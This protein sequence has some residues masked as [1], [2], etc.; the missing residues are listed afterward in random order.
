MGNNTDFFNYV[1]QQLNLKR[2]ISDSYDKTYIDTLINLYYTKL[3]VDNAL[4]TKLNLT[5]ITN[6]YTKLQT[7]IF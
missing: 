2:N 3:Q 4:N 6:Y 7:D 1:N 5:E